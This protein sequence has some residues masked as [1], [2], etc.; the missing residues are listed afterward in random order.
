MRQKAIGARDGGADLLIVPRENY[1]E[2]KKTIGGALRIVPVG[3]F[4]EA[5]RALARS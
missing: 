4:R 5:L 1:A 3:T 2:A